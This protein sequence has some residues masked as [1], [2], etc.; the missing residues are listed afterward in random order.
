MNFFNYAKT[1]TPRQLECSTICLANLFNVIGN[2]LARLTFEREFV[3][4][5][6]RFATDLAIEEQ[7]LGHQQKV[8]A[9]FYILV[10]LIYKERIGEVCSLRQLNKSIFSDRLLVKSLLQ[11]SLPLEKK[12]AKFYGIVIVYLSNRKN[13]HNVRKMIVKSILLNFG[14]IDHE[15]TLLN[16]LVYLRN[17]K[18]KVTINLKDVLEGKMVELLIRAY[19]RHIH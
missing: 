1:Y 14:R 7:Q 13:T 11:I 2:I 6:R 10:A 9:L 15:P 17:E 18:N 16:L 12:A 19:P 8:Q 4:K 3:V 5:L